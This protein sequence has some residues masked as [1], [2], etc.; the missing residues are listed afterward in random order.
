M[1]LIWELLDPLEKLTI[2]AKYKRFKPPEP[3]HDAFALLEDIE[4][5]AEIME[6][7]KAIEV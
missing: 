1:P 2:K 7:R 3:K 5:I 6:E 4:E